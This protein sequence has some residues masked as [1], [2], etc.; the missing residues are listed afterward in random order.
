MFEAYFSLNGGLGFFL[1]PI[2]IVKHIVAQMLFV[3]LRS[4][5]LSLEI[6]RI[7]FGSLLA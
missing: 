1:P 5:P 7:T 2:K 6:A 3:E 4:K